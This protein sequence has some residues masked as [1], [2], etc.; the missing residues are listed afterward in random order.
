MLIRFLRRPAPIDERLF[1]FGVTFVCLGLL[2]PLL[3]TLV[4]PSKGGSVASAG[5]PLVV[6]GAL[7]SLATGYVIRRRQRGRHTEE[8]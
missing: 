1:A 4:D 3:V 7:I 2:V 6:G 8:D 5:L